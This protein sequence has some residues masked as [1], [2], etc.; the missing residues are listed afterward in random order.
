M[1]S[2]RLNAKRRATHMQDAIK[3]VVCMCYS[4]RSHN[5]RYQRKL[6]CTARFRFKTILIQIEHHYA[7]QIPFGIFDSSPFFPHSI[8]SKCIFMDT[9]AHSTQQLLIWQKWILIVGTWDLKSCAEIYQKWISLFGC[10]VRF[11]CVVYTLNKRCTYENQVF[12]YVVCGSS[13][14]ELTLIFQLKIHNFFHCCWC[15]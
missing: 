1:H 11:F 6:H 12:G 13:A 5:A 2:Q 14:L 9:H 4:F 3:V 15:P 8:N 7:P 10:F